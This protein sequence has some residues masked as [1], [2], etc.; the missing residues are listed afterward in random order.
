MLR[1]GIGIGEAL[2]VRRQGGIASCA[3]PPGACVDRYTSWSERST[4]VS[5]KL[6][7]GPLT[8]MSPRD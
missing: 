1:I 8:P 3:V 7:G 4:S 6:V 2:E 5:S